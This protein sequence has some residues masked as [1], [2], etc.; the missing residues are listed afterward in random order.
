MAIEIFSKTLTETDISVRL[1]VP[2]DA[3]RHIN[4]PEGANKVYLFPRDANREEWP[5]LCY[6]RLNGHPKPAFTTGWLDFVRAKG[7]QIGD[8]VI[9]SMLEGEAGGGPQ[10]RIHAK[11][12]SRVFTLMGEEVFAWVDQ[13]AIE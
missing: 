12:W 1:T 9:F 4:M 3:L 6:T 7:L 11:R 2:T 10:Y 13:P 5:F 8:T